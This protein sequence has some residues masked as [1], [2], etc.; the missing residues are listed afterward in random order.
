MSSFM[1]I[2]KIECSNTALLRE[3]LTI[4]DNMPL[5]WD[6]MHKPSRDFTEKLIVGLQETKEP[7]GFWILHES[8]GDHS[9][10]GILWAGIKITGRDFLSCVIKSIWLH[11]DFRKQNH[12]GLLTSEC[13]TWAKEHQVTRLTC[14]THFQNQ[15]MREILEKN[16]FMPGMIDYYREI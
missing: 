13:L 16:G 7:Q 10:K 11:P 3:I 8:E 15:R 4:H 12:T 5:E 2:T 14:D 9:I 6:P 1:E